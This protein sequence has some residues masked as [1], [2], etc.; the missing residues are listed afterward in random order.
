MEIVKGRCDCCLRED[1]E[2]AVIEKRVLVFFVVETKVCQ[3]CVSKIFRKFS[4]D[5]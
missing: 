2:C 1:N 4:K 5:K 3:S